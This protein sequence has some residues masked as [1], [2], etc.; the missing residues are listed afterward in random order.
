MRIAL[1][2]ARGSGSIRRA[3]VQISKLAGQANLIDN[4]TDTAIVEI[5]K[6]ERPTPEHG[7]IQTSVARNAVIIGDSAV[8]I[9]ESLFDVGRRRNLVAAFEDKR[10]V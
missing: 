5:L 8:V 3:G 7:V 6:F 2:L 4:L 1:S 10:M 9:R